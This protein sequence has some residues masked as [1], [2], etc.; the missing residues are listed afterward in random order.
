M[1]AFRSTGQKASH[2][3]LIPPQAVRKREIRPAGRDIVDVE[4]ETMGAHVRRSIYPVF[5][6]NRRNAAR[7]ATAE[8]AP[9]SASAV[10]GWLLTRLE[11]LLQ[12]VPT[13]VFAGVVTALCLGVFTLVFASSGVASSGPP[14]APLTLEHVTTALNDANGMKVISVFGAVENRSQTAQAVPTVTVDVIDNGRKTASIDVA[15]FDEPLQP[16]DTRP[17]TV[18]LPHAGGKIPAVRLS[19]DEAGAQRP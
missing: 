3:D 2:G 5:N 1:S 14:L 9:V 6:D 4:F 7:P 15:A 16:G 8:P 10:I 12:T 13:R 17:F 19:F 11:R 18:R